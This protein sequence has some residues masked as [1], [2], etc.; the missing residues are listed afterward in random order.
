M[1]KVAPDTAADA[2]FAA[3]TGRALSS[4]ASF[5]DALNHDGDWPSV[6]E[7]L[8]AQSAIT[9]RLLEQHVAEF[10]QWLLE[11]Q[12]GFHIFF[13]GYGSKVDLVA[14]LAQR[15]GSLGDVLCIDAFKPKFK[16]QDIVTA[17]QAGLA[18]D[19]ATD[20]RSKGTENHL[21]ALLD[22]YTESGGALYILINSIDAPA[23]SKGQGRAILSSLV[24]HPSVR[25]V[26]TVDK[27]HAP[28]MWSLGEISS[29]KRLDDQLV[30]Y[31]V[32]STDHLDLNLIWHDA[33]TL[34]PYIDELGSRDLRRTPKFS[35]SRG[36]KVV[37][38]SGDLVNET[39]VNHVLA[40]VTDR[41][42]KLFRLIGTRQLEQTSPSEGSRPRDGALTYSTT[43]MA[44][45]DAF[46]AQ[47]DNQMKSLL[48][49]FTDHGVV[50]MENDA[51]AG[52]EILWISMSLE[53]LKSV[54]E[55]LAP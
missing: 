31:G 23:L 46:L 21:A 51:E 13:Y 39:A 25:L 47:T 45:R 40:S 34:K 53:S 24:R 43:F 18:D 27:L 10:D 15:C 48:G 29:R 8:S 36:K 6:P 49:E 17:L 11:L 55:A 35:A 5:A 50:V 22:S 7:I 2:Y 26:G 3:H 19:S 42:K 28:T 14:R 30:E 52:G 33:T 1:P 44:A 37:T 38:K 9:D 4:K 16:A 12:E 20:K 32:D 54:L 41:A